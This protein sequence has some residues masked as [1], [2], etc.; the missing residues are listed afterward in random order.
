M[1][2]GIGIGFRLGA[3]HTEFLADR[4]TA[5]AVYAKQ[6]IFLNGQKAAIRR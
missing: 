2:L 3:Y 5:D 6:S 1:L 4:G